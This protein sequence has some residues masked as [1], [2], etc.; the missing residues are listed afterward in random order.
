MLTAFSW[1]QI[2]KIQMEL[3]DL[4][5][6]PLGYEILSTDFEVNPER[7]ITTTLS[8]AG[9]LIDIRGRYTTGKTVEQWSVFYKNGEPIL[10]QLKKWRK[11]S[12]EDEE[13]GEGLVKV[14]TILFKDGR[15]D[16][17]DESFKIRLKDLR[18]FAATKKVKQGVGE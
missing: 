13:I 4:K 2:P 12:F 18:A 9:D 17:D 8:A 6:G 7:Q 11:I 5:I 16:T 10:A 1:G 15:F 3:K 14:E